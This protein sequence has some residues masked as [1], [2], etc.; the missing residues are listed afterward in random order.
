MT[1][2]Q[3]EQYKIY[4]DEQYVCYDVSDLFYSDL[5]QYVESMVS[6][7]SD[8]YFDE[9]VW[10]RVQ[11]IYNYY[12]DN[13][14]SL[15]GYR[16]G[17]GHGTT[18]TVTKTDASNKPENKPY[19]RDSLSEYRLTTESCYDDPN[20]PVADQNYEVGEPNWND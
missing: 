2:E 13:M 8:V 18:E 16:D 11:N 9:Q 1:F 20:N 6:Q 19:T 14:G 12:R 4:E 15:L 7:R 17:M 5:R 10:E 3:M